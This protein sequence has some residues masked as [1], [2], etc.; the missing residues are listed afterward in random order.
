MAVSGDEMRLRNILNKPE[1]IR[2]SAYFVSAGAGRKLFGVYFLARVSV[3]LSSRA[4]VL[5]SAGAGCAICS[6]EC[7][8][9]ENIRICTQMI[10]K[11]TSR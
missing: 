3:S 7:F 10:P 2:D 1:I 11:K 8:S 6:I 9:A 5:L 4:R